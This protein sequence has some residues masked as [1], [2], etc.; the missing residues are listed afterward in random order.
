MY[1][2]LYDHSFFAAKAIAPKIPDAA[3]PAE[4]IEVPEAKDPQ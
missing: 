1:R 4:V 2:D 3:Q